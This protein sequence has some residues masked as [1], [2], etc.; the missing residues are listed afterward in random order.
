MSETEIVEYLEQKLSASS[1]IKKV[2]KKIYLLVDILVWSRSIS[3]ANFV[4]GRV[5]L[6]ITN[7]R[8]SLSECVE[9]TDSKHDRHTSS[10][11]SS[12]LSALQPSTT[13]T[14]RYQKQSKSGH[15]AASHF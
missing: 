7:T 15:V 11:H 13:T 12:R 9:H 8:Y 5:H 10:K 2:K 1:D 6:G 14:Q 3:N 4:G